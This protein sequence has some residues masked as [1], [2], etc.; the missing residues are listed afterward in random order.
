M[1]T[2]FPKDLSTPALQAILQGAIAPRP[3]AFASTLSKEGE[4]NLSPF[5]FFNVFSAQPPILIFSPSRRVRD[6]STKHTLENVLEVPEVVIH[7]VGF[8]LV[9]QMSLASTEYPR[10]V[11]EFIK[12]GLTP[13]PSQVVSPPR[14]KEAPISFECKVNQVMP[15]GDQ[16]GAGN[17]VICEV[18]V[19]HLDERILDEDGAIHPLKLKPVA[20][21]GGNWYSQVTSDSLFQIP[22]PLTTLGIG[23]DQLPEHI[24]MSPVLTGNHLG[25][26]GN[27][28]QLPD[29]LALADFALT[30]EVQE[31]KKRFHMDPE[32]WVNHLHHWA[33]EE[34]EAGHVELAWKILLQKL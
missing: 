7:V 4:V 15:L 24:R 29:A 12:A 5:S 14:V 28:E 27:V 33:K 18:Q 2:I 19:I 21:L 3:I 10:G 6:N 20:R 17:L 22:K 16:G 31:L 26:L 13:I 9:E 25:R 30:P 8:D 34:L 11:N 23:V 1:K 32:S